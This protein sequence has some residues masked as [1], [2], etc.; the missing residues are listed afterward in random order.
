MTV[1]STLLRI[2]PLAAAL[3]LTP[4]RND[5]EARMHLRL[6]KS[7]PAA[8]STVS[9]PR[10]LRLWFSLR[11]QLTITTVTLT[12]PGERPGP[13]GK[14]AMASGAGAPVTVPVA[15]TLSPGTWRVRWKTASRDMHLM[16]GEFE[17]T[18]K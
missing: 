9:S 1:G 10:D 5:A 3:V 6:T 18:V 14:P 11:P 7:E 4:A 17:F 8:G 12:G 2:I 15:G 13:L 16:T